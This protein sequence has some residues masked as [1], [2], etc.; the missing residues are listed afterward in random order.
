MKTSFRSLFLFIF[1]FI[2]LCS[3][4]SQNFS[5][6]QTHENGVYRKGEKIQVTL[7]TN[8]S[9]ADSLFI[10]V[11]K[12]NDQLLLKKAVLPTADPL[13]V[14]EGVFKEPCSVS[15]EAR[16][17]GN[18]QLLGLVVAPNKLKPGSAYPKDLEAFW[19][20]EKLALNALRM[21]VK[22]KTMELKDSGYECQD[23]EINCTGPKPSRGY[24]AKPSGAKVRSLPIVLL[25]HAAEVKGNWCR[26]E[27]SNAMNYAKKGAL[28]FDLN[29]H[30]ML[31]GQPEEYYSNLETGELKDYYIQGLEDREKFYFRGMYL[32]LIRTIEFLTRQPEWDGKRIIVIGESQGGG[33]ALAAAGLDQRVSAV[34]AT[35]PAMCDWGGTLTGRK[36]GWPQPFERKGDKEKMLN[37]LPYFDAA[38]LLKNS[39][40]MIVVEIGLVDQTCPST[41]I[42]A[43]INQ[44]K[45]IKIIY[46][47]PYREH[48]WPNAEQRKNWD[49]MVFNPKNEF[50]EN[51]LR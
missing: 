41:S 30:G 26:S 51:Y 50:V 1:L 35:V 36:G 9:V 2:F 4:Q 3:V 29:A 34:V 13:I 8:Q 17:R 15:L 38:H 49:P 47:V 42:Y 19:D 37:V 11:W 22:A 43:S 5:L 20:L 28:C 6:K 23:I 10:K 40:A 27:V 24:F 12:N 39:K 16:Q 25:V 7:S 48:S 33:Q 32:R 44:A 18:K 45:G 31:N 46:P 14:Y 21:E